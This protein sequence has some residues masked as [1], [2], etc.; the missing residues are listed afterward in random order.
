M[1]PDDF[2]IVR[3]HFRT[4]VEGFVGML[5]RALGSMAV[6]PR[7]YVM[8]AELDARRYVQFWIDE[9]GA[10]TGET[11]PICRRSSGTVSEQERHLLQNAGWCAPVDV[12]APNWWVT[13][14]GPTFLMALINMVRHTV[15]SLMCLGAHDSVRVHVWTVESGETCS[16]R[17]RVEAR[18]SYHEALRSLRRALD[19]W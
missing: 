17:M 19:G 5:A 11:S 9:D 18:V 8:V 10:V 2:N 14:R 12:D 3:E 15:G 16:E 7:S 1:D 6:E 4:D 13:G